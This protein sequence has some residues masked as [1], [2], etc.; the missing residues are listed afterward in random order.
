MPQPYSDDLRCKLLEAYTAGAGSL[1]E[2]AAQFRVSWGYSKKIRVQQVQTGQTERPAQ[3]RHGPVSRVTEEV[4]EKLRNW[5][6]Q[7]P[8]LTLAEL[9]EQMAGSGVRVSRSRVH[10]V[11]QQLGLRR[12]KNLSTPKNKIRNRVGA[13]V[14]RGGRQ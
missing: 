4:Q 12:K 3:L 8:D 9:R 6:R 13:A 2:L 7:R 14:R 11:V 10:Q 1:R 5:L